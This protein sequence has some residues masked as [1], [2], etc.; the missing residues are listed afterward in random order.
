MAFISCFLG[1]GYFSSGLWV[2]NES[3]RGSPT[4][5]WLCTHAHPSQPRSLTSSSSSAPLTRSFAG[6]LTMWMSPQHGTGY[7]TASLCLSLLPSSLPTSDFGVISLQSISLLLASFSSC[8][9][10]SEHCLSH[11]YEN[12]NIWSQKFSCSV[13]TL[14]AVATAVRTV[15]NE[16]IFIT[17]DQPAVLTMSPTAARETG[18]LNSLLSVPHILSNSGKPLLLQLLS[19]LAIL[20]D[21][22]M[23]HRPLMANPLFLRGSGELFL[24]D[25]TFI[26][27]EWLS[28]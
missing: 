11:L 18:F 23:V 24:C 25:L 3:P 4:S 20:L 17:G 19:A 9:L 1:H 27:S 16:V 28:S 13:V 7:S 14:A 26:C 21:K 22:L 2:S 12:E 5:P 6:T 15:Q 10:S 8:A